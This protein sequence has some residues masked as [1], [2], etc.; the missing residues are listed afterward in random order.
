MESKLGNAEFAKNAPPEVIAKDQQRLAELRT[1]LNQLSA[2]IARVSGLQRPMTAAQSAIGAVLAQINRV[3]L[4]KEAQIR[5]CL[6]CLLAR[7]HFLIEDIPGVGKTT[8]AH[9]IAKSLGL[10][11]QRVQFTSD[12]L[13]SDV[14]GVSIF[15]RDTGKFRFQHGPIFAQLVLADEINRASPKAQSALLE[16]MEE[17]QVTLD[18][19]TLALPEP[20]FVIATQNP[21][22]QAGTFPLP[23]SQLDR[24]LMRVH[25]GYPAA[26]AE[27]ELLNGVDRRDLVN[28]L[29]TAASLEV[30]QDLQQRVNEVHVSGAL[31]DYVQALVAHS[32]LAP[33]FERRSFAACGHRPAARG[34]RLCA[35]RRARRRHPGA[36]AGGVRRGGRSIAY[37]C[38]TAAHRPWHG[39]SRPFQSRKK[40][41]S[42]RQAASNT[43][44]AWAARRHG[45]DALPLKIQRRRVYILPTRFGLILAAV[46]VAML[47]AGLNY[48]SNLGLA[49][50]FLM[51]SMALVA[52][53]HCNRNLLGIEVDAALEAD[54][55]AGGD[56][57]F[58]FVLRNASNLERRD[59]EI[60]IGTVGATR[61]VP[62]R[63][64]ESSVIAVATPQRGVVR[65]KQFE[66]RTR[67]PFGWFHAWTYVHAALT[68]FVAPAPRGNQA[69]AIAAGEGAA[70][71]S[72]VRGDEDFAGLRAYEPG[73]PLKHMAWKVLARG[74]EPAVRSYTG[75]AAQPEWLEWSALADLGPEER[76][77]QLC[78]WVGESETAQRV[79]GLRIPGAE[80]APSRGAAHRTACL[81]ALACFGK[82]PLS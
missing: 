59:V 33:G 38:A 11:F 14:L 18:G 12:L 67:Y 75:S 62:A 1:E 26:A 7:G 39:C 2:Q 63:S 74:A 81:R 73:V 37:A 4:G 24:F 43:L 71:W 21:Q 70:L 36:R 16:A 5:L 69:L 72:E 82:A 79:Y 78:L 44:R 56:A 17:H 49:F 10:S 52:M 30:L 31:L 80:V 8:L 65:F 57:R 48:N 53:H 20:F 66:L 41:P 27:R 32:R 22:D 34:A 29:P 54:A 77:S 61:S 23:E 15:D 68:V 35:H 45:R 19:Q 58:D 47:I 3:I 9:A 60:R 6:T 51:A 55:Y 50:A 76:L 46:L 13:P 28:T 25:L 40:M 42:I 64:G